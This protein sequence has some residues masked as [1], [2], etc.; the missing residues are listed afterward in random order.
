MDLWSESM[1]SFYQPSF[2]FLFSVPLPSVSTFIISFILSRLASFALPF[3]SILKR[4]F[5]LL[6]WNS[7]SFDMDLLSLQF[8]SCQGIFQIPYVLV[9]SFIHFC[10]LSL[11]LWLSFTST[12]HSESAI[13]FLDTENSWLHFVI[14]LHCGMNEQECISWDIGQVGTDELKADPEIHTAG[15]SD[16][17]HGS[18][19]LS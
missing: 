4:R 18:L 13:Q 16:R 15:H 14:F 2:V 3:L 10:V 9:S 5:G 17:K 6:I 11:S 19:L 7:S 1:F 8:F 12:S